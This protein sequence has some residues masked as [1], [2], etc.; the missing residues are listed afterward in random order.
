MFNCIINT[1]N[2]R[3]IH[4]NGGKCTWSNNQE[5]PTLERLDR[6][7]VSD[8]WEQEFPL[9][10]LRKIPRYM[11]DHN[12]LILCTDMDQKK[13][14]RSF[15]FETS[16]LKH[17]DFVPKISEIWTRPVTANSAVVS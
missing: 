4:M 9:A 1:H 16:W 12:P 2:L 8:D 11:S 6:V 3:D 13:G 5:N 10:N 14:G 7:L 17:H 15:C